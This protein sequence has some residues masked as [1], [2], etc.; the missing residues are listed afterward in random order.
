MLVATLDLKEAFPAVPL[1]LA[2]LALGPT[3]AYPTYR[4]LVGRSVCPTSGR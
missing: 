2:W 3:K 4:M 1:S